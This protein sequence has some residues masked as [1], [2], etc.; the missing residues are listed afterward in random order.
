MIAFAP[1]LPPAVELLVLLALLATA[2]WI[3]VRH[4][5][6][7][8]I[9]PRLL[10]IALFALVLHNPV[11][12]LP[13]TAGT[14]RVALVLDA[15]AS[16]AISDTGTASRAAQA[17]QALEGVAAGAGG[18]T[19][20]RFALSDELHPGWP[21]SGASA[22]AGTDFSGLA[23]FATGEPPV[24]VVLA[25]DG[26]DHGSQA[27]D[28]DL[29]AAGVPVYVV[30]VG[31][32]L[33]A[34]NAAVRLEAPGPSAFVAQELTLTAVV[35][36]TPDLYGRQAEVRW[37]DASGERATVT[38]AA[39]VRLPIAV[40]AGTTPGERRWSATL[41]TPAGAQEATL[42][43]N[44]AEVAVQV[45]DRRLRVTVIS[46]QP[47]WDEAALVRARRRDQQLA[48]TTS[49]R[50]GE[51]TTTTTGPEGELPAGADPLANADL[52][53]VG[54]RASAVLDAAQ[55]ARLVEQVTHGCGL[56]L[57]AGWRG[58]EDPLLALDPVLWPDA[59]EARPLA[60]AVGAAARRLAVLPEGAVL[61]AVMAA[62]ASSL[63][64]G[65]EVLLGEPGRPLLTL[66][67]HGAG[68][69]VAVNAAGTWRWAQEDAE[70][71]G[72]FWRQLVRAVVADAA[73]SL[74][75]D[76]AR[77]RVGQTA[78]VAVPA[79]YQGEISIAAPDGKTARQHGGPLTVALPIAGRWTVTA[80]SESCSLLVED[81]VRELVDTARRDDRLA[82][83]AAVT[84][85]AVVTA[86]QA[87]ELGA[88]LARRAALRGTAVPPTPLITAVWWPLALTFLL[89]LEWW[90][91]RRRHGAL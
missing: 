51:H 5:L 42:L 13:P 8:L 7:W 35:T 63:R 54:P 26:A 49:Y 71:S 72:R 64:P 90:L 9:V 12:V 16:M 60:P 25:S 47:W 43:D 23:R 28:A 57:T 74:R 18:L 50:V 70:I 29:A 40:A 20:E 6:H 1:L 17:R 79:G 82:R 55:T 65:S 75:P 68:R 27:P 87:G 62:A 19:V 67:R 59:A 38:L 33:P 39:E 24:A 10:A 4:G 88:R 77:Y 52:I 36:A 83:L 31:G 69:V 21:E 56:M 44:H 86:A 45:V 2:G 58:S 15:S 85:G 22:A 34:S 3:Y 76:R 73:T 32:L 14:P 48:V 61:P 41:T 30:A 37:G 89:G 46:G 81:D 80:G 91:R 11:T 66:G 84:G 78:E 53:V